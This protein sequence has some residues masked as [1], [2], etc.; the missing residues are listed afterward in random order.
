VLKNFIYYWKA[1]RLNTADGPIYK[2]NQNSTRMSA[3]EPGHR[4]WA[5]TYNG[6]GDY[7][8]IAAFQV[9]EMG[10]NP[11]DSPDRDQWGRWFFCSSPD[12]T[13]YFDPVG[14]TTVEPIVRRLGLTTNAA[15]LGQSLQG[16]H[17]VQQIGHEAAKLLE[18][19]ARTIKVDA[20]LSTPVAIENWRKS[21]SLGEDDGADPPERREYRRELALR[22]R[23]HVQELK[24][25]YGGR[26]QV[27]G[28]MPLGGLVGDIT[29]AHHI[30][31]LTRGG[32]D[33]KDNMIVLSPDMH[34]AVH[35]ADATFDWSE[36][37][38]IINGKRVPLKLNVHL[39]RRARS[40]A[41]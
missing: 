3:I 7:A 34:R 24:A 26:C 17:G 28:E 30:H 8:L 9:N 18:E 21:S 23:R 35:T 10:E 39:R 16:K 36:L 20:R 41:R 6:P 37:D 33:S 31:W 40:G 2:L 22:D 4:V 19:H 32:A 13:V 27:S 29:E 1:Y 11:P 25:L 12:H 15:I 38:F 14:Q 5:I